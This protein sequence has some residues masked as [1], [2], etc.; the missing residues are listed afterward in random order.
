MSADHLI[1][2]AL[3]VLG[4]L[5]GFVAVMALHEWRAVNREKS[6]KSRDD[7]MLKEIRDAR[8]I[9]LGSRQEVAAIKIDVEDLKNRT[10]DLEGRVARL[11]PVK[12]H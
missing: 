5:V 4:S 1:I 11:E 3:S 6:S 8:A 12:V 7:T 2:F 9:F 10:A